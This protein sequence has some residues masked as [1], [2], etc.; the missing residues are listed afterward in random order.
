MLSLHSVLFSLALILTLDQRVPKEALRFRYVMEQ[1]LDASCG[2]ATVATALSLYWGVPVQEAELL[3][4]LFGQAGG[5]S[6]RT[7]GTVNL[8]SMAAAFEYRGVSARAFH[9]DWDG[10]SEVLARGYAPVVVHYDRPDPHFAL[11]LGISGGVAVLADPARGLETLGRAG[12]EH[13]YSGV[14]MA[15][16]SRS[17]HRNLPLLEAAIQGAIGRRTILDRSSP[18]PPA[19]KVRPGW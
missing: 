3:A 16:A 9:L 15:L 10:L 2:M 17:L 4:G 6:G 14:A 7:D 19:V 8:A 5:P 11:L 13:R 18:R 1:G 12:F